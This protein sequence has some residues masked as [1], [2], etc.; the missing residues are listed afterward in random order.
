M[1]SFGSQL[2]TTIVE[3]HL[4]NDQKN[5]CY[6][7]QVRM[8]VC[9]PKEQFVS[10]WTEAWRAPR[11]T[12]YTLVPTMP[13]SFPTVLGQGI[14]GMKGHCNT[15]RFS[16]YTGQYLCFCSVTETDA[17]AMLFST[18]SDTMA[19]HWQYMAIDFGSICRTEASRCHCSVHI[20]LVPT[21]SWCSS[22]ALQVRVGWKQIGSSSE[23]EW[24]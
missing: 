19:S 22:Q 9:I 2:H 4:M 20:S 24:A 13:W 3:S 21:W 6:S 17:A 16:F 18:P 5:L 1:F 7:Y 23:D 15:N 8:Q 14:N 10:N 11:D 12:D